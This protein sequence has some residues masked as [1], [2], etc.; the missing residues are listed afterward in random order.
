MLAHSL[1]LL[2]SIVLD[3]KESNEQNKEK[4]RVLKEMSE[5]VDSAFMSAAQALSASA[6]DTQILV[7]LIKQVSLHS[8]MAG[9]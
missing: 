5:L 9:L 8:I 2:F 4:L 6:G 1:V 7:G 3:S